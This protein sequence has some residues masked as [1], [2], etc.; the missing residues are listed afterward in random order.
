MAWR[1]RTLGTRHVCGRTRRCVEVIAPFDLLSQ[2]RQTEVIIKTDRGQMVSRVGG[3]KGRTTTLM[4]L[5]GRLDGAVKSIQVVGR[6]DLTVAE[7]ARDEYILLLLMNQRCLRTSDFV[8]TVW[9]PTALPAPRGPPQHP[10]TQ[11]PSLNP[12]QSRVVDAMMNPTIPLV[13]VQGMDIPLEF[14]LK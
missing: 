1:S 5:R 8:R 4:S 9:F 6:E 12:S 7:R 10:T 2:L 3:V 13:V 11:R 14:C